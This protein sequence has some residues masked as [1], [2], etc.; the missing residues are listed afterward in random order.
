[1][2]WHDL[3]PPWYLPERPRLPA[4]SARRWV[5]PQPE[6]RTARADTVG[7]RRSC[8]NNGV[9]SSGLPDRVE[10]YLE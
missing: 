5:N 4:P 9:G 3:P 6:R 10:R 1:L 7:G 8:L 2:L